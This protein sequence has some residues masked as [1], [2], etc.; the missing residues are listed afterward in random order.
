MPALEKSYILRVPGLAAEIPVRFGHES[1]KP[2]ILAI[3][4]TS[5]TTTTFRVPVRPGS[6]DLR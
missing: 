6:G 4:T 5:V 2:L 1:A 3:P